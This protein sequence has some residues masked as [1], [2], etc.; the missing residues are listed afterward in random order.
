MNVTCR[1]DTLFIDKERC[2]IFFK[3]SLAELNDIKKA[4]KTKEEFYVASDGIAEDKFQM[5]NILRRKQYTHH[6]RRYNDKSYTV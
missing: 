2:A 5:K 4:Y 3:L 6:L 1:K